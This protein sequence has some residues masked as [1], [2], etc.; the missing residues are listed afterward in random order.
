[1]KKDVML[2]DSSE[3]NHIQG[4]EVCRKYLAL[5]M[6]GPIR[7]FPTKEDYRKRDEEQNQNVKDFIG[8][9]RDI[10]VQHGI[11]EGI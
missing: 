9:N 11:F 4:C 1:M 5:C 7:G 2:I 6:V 8:K 10:L 3:M